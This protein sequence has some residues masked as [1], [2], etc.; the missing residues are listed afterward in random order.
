MGKAGPAE[1]AWINGKV[2]TAADLSA[3]A[4][5]PYGHFTTL[6]VRGRAARGLDL[7]LQRL[8]DATRELFEQTL[9][10]ERVRN[11]MRDALAASGCSD[12]TL[13][14]AVHARGFDLA[15]MEGLDEVDLLVR[16][17]SP[18]EPGTRPL[19]LK[20][21]IYARPLPHLKHVGT[22]PLFHHRRQ[23][24]RA[25]G[26]DA[27]LVDGDGRIAEG[28]FWNIGFHD[29][30]TVVW[31]QAPALRGTCE[32]LLQAGLAQLGVGQ[33]AR[34]VALGDLGALGG[35][36]VANSRG[37]QAVAAIDEMAWAPDPAFAG[38]LR[39]ALDTQPWQA[40]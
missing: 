7:H 11:A 32:R 1:H 16:I 19:Q 5:V 36:F 14:L 39:R 28:T 3:I 20:S 29:G 34:P 17:A 22:F 33:E 10:A 4:A 24:V 35:A 31:P 23:A 37:V 13:R 9:D 26:D 15:R 6:Q 30:D 27:L 21:V 38:L 12:C 8:Q 25:G 2:A 40:I 18:G